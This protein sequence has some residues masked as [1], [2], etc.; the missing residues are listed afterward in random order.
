[1]KKVKANTSR[2]N[3]KPVAYIDENGDVVL[4]SDIFPMPINIRS[5]IGAF[6]SPWKLNYE[7][8]KTDAV[9]TPPKYN[10]STAVIIPDEQ[11]LYDNDISTYSS[12]EFYASYTIN[13][14]VSYTV[15]LNVPTYIEKIILIAK[16]TYSRALF[17][18]L[19]L[20]L[21]FY[22]GTTLEIKSPDV[23]NISGG[24]YS[25]SFDIP[26][27]SSTKKVVWFALS[28][29]D[30]T[31]AIP[32]KFDA[33]GLY[34][35][36]NPY[37][38]MYNILNSLLNINTRMAKDSVR[39]EDRVTDSDDF[40]ASGEEVPYDNYTVSS[41]KR[42]IVRGDL[43]VYDDLHVIGDIRVIGDV[44]VGYGGEP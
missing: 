25:I 15:T 29:T 21:H 7:D 31:H 37:K 18:Y 20:E 43:F 19:R 27:T 34:V 3:A 32:Q 24:F 5:A 40:V 33:Y 41:G 16:D 9:T 42:T 11:K 39:V 28:S 4:A 1:M 14:N 13:S 10:P 36:V 30:G 35:Y 17:D 22:D 6:T 44:Y 12:V 23:H 26:T 8:V 2:T 38:V